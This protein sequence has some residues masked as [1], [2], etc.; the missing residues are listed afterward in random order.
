MPKSQEEPGLSRSSP[1]LPIQSLWVKLL[2]GFMLVAMIAVGTVA[3][4]ANRATTREFEL[5]VSQGKQMRA[6]RLAPEFAAYYARTGSWTGVAE[7]MAD[8]DTAPA[9]S[10]GRG[11]G[12]G[13]GQGEGST[14][15][16]LLLANTKGQIIADSDGTLIGQQ[17]SDKDRASGVPIQVE[18]QDVGVLLVTSPEAIHQSQEA[19]FLR[20]VNQALVWAGLAAGVIALILGALLARQ[21]TAPLRALTRAAQS[22]SEGQ[23]AQ[24][25]VRS[26]DEIGELGQAFNHMAH[27]LAEQERLRRNLMADIAHELRTPLAVMR[28]DLE[29]LLDGVYEPTGEA[30]ASLHEETLLLSR[31]VDDL[32]ALAQAE[33]GQL[34]LVRK[35][36][37]LG[38]LLHGVV[39]GF[40][41][42]AESQGQALRLELSPDLPPLYVD[43]QRVRQI[44]AN[45]LSNALRHAPGSGRIVLSATR[46]PGTVQISVSDDG[47]GLAPDELPHVF[48]RFWRGP[49]GRAG[50]SGLGLAIAHEL[51]RAHGGQIW[52]ESDLGKGSTF[53]FT[54]PLYGESPPSLP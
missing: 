8:L 42:L 37:D 7:W 48:D 14:T 33:A 1:R 41:L 31:L 51:V 43:P 26:H 24:V 5:Y 25:R 53:H 10:G 50:G 44:V 54:L 34:Q 40:D 11:L 35:P 52:V 39:D 17:L 12:R 36:T 47:P 9:Q 32:R 21:L 4:L 19:E 23:V 18:G 28:G 38:E 20:Q 15:D 30:L 3:V 13:R 46:Q 45:L 29:A 49:A 2:I 22:L 16:R 6:E 27:A